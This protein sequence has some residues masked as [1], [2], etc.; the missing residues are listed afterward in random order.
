MNIDFNRKKDEDTVLWVMT[1][2]TDEEIRANTP[3]RVE[4]D[5]EESICVSLTEKMLEFNISFRL[6]EH[7]TKS[8]QQITGDI[9][10]NN[11]RKFPVVWGRTAHQGQMFD[12]Y[13]QA[14]DP[15]SVST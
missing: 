10:V 15:V 6:A 1:I 8:I 4:R 7:L 3:D 13:L 12:K 9:I 5:K 11:E 14:S 2:E